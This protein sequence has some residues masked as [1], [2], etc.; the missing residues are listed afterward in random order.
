MEVGK[1][2][3]ITRYQPFVHCPSAF[4]CDD[5]FPFDLNLAND[6]ESL[7]LVEGLRTSERLDNSI[8]SI[9]FCKLVMDDLIS[10]KDLRLAEPRL[11]LTIL[12]CKSWT[13]SMM[14]VG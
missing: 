3:S 12:S 5:S 6:N 2:G 11:G 7:E 14:S 9:R 8:S 4:F 10:P 1:K 13:A